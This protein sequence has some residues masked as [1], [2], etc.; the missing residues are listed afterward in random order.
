MSEYQISHGCEHSFA[1]V[2]E[3]LVQK[4]LKCGTTYERFVETQRDDWKQRAEKAVAATQQTRQWLDSAREDWIWLSKLYNEEK[5]KLQQA[6][7]ERDEATAHID[8][9]KDDFGRI[10]ALLRSDYLE[11]EIEGICE[12]ALAVTTQKFPLI[13]QRDNAEKERDQ[14]RAENANIKRTL[15][16]LEGLLND[17]SALWAEMIQP[18]RAENERLKLENETLSWKEWGCASP[19]KKDSS[20]AAD[21][22]ESLQALKKKLAEERTYAGYKDDTAT[23]F[24]R[25]VKRLQAENERLKLSLTRISN[26]RCPLCSLEAQQALDAKGGSDK[27][28]E[29]CN[30]TGISRSIPEGQIACPSC[31]AKGEKYE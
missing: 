11:S 16:K 1:L 12:R 6:E 23:T 22:E 20:S 28:C 26:V 2:G 9:M 4:C 21:S 8:L 27:V 15:D 25:Q 18:L 5:I 10:I 7:R 13:E 17:P 19:S 31:A 29:T 30:G 24:M 14:L 3:D